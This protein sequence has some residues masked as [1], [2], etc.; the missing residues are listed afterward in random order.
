MNPTHEKHIVGDVRLAHERDHPVGRGNR[1][2][3]DRGFRRNVLDLERD[4][5]NVSHA[6]TIG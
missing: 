2:S 6:E 4:C 5:A 1:N 3:H